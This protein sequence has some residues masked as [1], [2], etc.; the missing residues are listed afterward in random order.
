MSQIKAK[1]ILVVEDDEIDFENFRRT[2]YKVTQDYALVHA[3]DGQEA[4]DILLGKSV[5]KN[6]KP[7]PQ[8]MLLD[9][10]LPRLSGLEML[11]QLRAH[12]N[13]KSIS[14]F[15]LTSSD[16]HADIIKAYEL[17]V[18]G[19]LQKPFGKESMLEI[20]K[21]LEKYWNINKFPERKQGL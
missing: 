11:L 15:I 1:N 20:V 5:D 17:N 9:I 2:F 6:I 8:I 14:V 19:Y 12:E 4:L 13:I 10:N 21:T 3:V 18:A 7:V 16:A